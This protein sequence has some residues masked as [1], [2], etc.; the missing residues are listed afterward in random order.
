LKAV[1]DEAAKVG[2][3]VNVHSITTPWTMAALDLGVRRFVHLP[4]RDWTSHEAAAKMAATSTIVA[5]LNAFGAPIIDRL[6]GP[7]APVQFPKDTHLDSADGNRGPKGS[8][9]RPATQS[10]KATGNGSRLPHCERPTIWD[11]GTVRSASQTD[12]NYPIS[13]F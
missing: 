11:A 9:P 5:G 10:E 2:V 1:V 7:Q 12:Q 6:S 4:E 8:Q 13:S 3:Q